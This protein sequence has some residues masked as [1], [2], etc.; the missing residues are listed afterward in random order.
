MEIEINR[1]I[2]NCVI[3]RLKGSSFSKY[4]N[5]STCLFL[6]SKESTESNE[7]SC[8]ATIIRKKIADEN[9]ENIGE[10]SRYVGITWRG[11]ERARVESRGKD[12]S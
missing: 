1:G 10:R 3:V 11:E 8:C 4:I 12:Q 7:K 9:S 5:T 2:V 6:Y